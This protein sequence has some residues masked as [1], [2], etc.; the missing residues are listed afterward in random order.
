MNSFLFYQLL[1]NT[2]DGSLLLIDEPEISLHISW[3]NQFINDLKEVIK[4][5]SMDILIATHSPD[6]ISNYWNLTKSA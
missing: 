2:Q 1:F 3:Q 5:N 6:I 4:I